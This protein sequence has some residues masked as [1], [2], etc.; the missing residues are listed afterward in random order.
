MIMKALVQRVNT[1]TTIYQIIKLVANQFDLLRTN[2]TEQGDDFGQHQ[3]R[4]YIAR[5]K[6]IGSGTRIRNTKRANSGL[7]MQPSIS[8]QRDP[9]CVCVCV[10][11]HSQHCD[12]LG[13][14]VACLC[15]Q[16]AS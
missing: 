8:I 13:S 15:I 3:T 16:H 2:S 12:L 10:Q 4:K 11:L 1:H 9:L 5:T 14:C 6:I 7:E